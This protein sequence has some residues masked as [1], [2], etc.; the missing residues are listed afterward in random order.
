MRRIAWQRRRALS[1]VCGVAIHR[2]FSAIRSATLLPRIAPVKC[3]C[4]AARYIMARSSCWIR[5]RSSGVGAIV[6][7]RQVQRGGHDQEAGAASPKNRRIKRSVTQSYLAA[8]AVD[9]Q[10]AQSKPCPKGGDQALGDGF[11]R[12][13]VAVPS[14]VRRPCLHRHPLA[15]A[16][17]LPTIA[18]RR[19]GFRQGRLSWANNRRRLGF[20]R[21]KP[22]RGSP[23]RA[24]LRPSRAGCEML[25]TRCNRRNSRSESL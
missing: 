18:D 3:H 23:T 6:L 24:P 9:E 17:G 8:D 7:D 13:C 5:R 21:S 11:A 16:A 15:A 4:G 20:Q 19:A 25:R 12:R 22:T 10:I 14:A 1:A 2:C